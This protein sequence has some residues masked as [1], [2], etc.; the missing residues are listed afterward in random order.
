[1][2]GIIAVCGALL[3]PGCG[4]IGHTGSGWD[5]A[6]APPPAETCGSVRLTSYTASSG[7]WC[8]YDRT[9]A[10]L[11]ASVRAGLTTAI[12]EPWNGG[13]Y[14]GVPGEACGE[15]WEVS[16]I[17]DTRIVMVHDL[18]PIEGN[19]LCAGAHFHFDLAGEAGQ[20]LRGGGL[21]EASTRRVPCPVAGNIHAQ[22]KDRNQWGYL[23]LQLINHRI[24]VRTIDYRAAG[25]ATWRPVQR[26]GG[27]WHVVD[28]PDG[29]FASGSP[30]GV[31]RITSAQGETVE[32]TN[33]LTY[34]IASGS[35]FDLGVQ[36]TDQA[37]ATGAAC[38]FTPPAVVWDDAF[39]G[40]D[41]VRWQVN[42]W[43]ASARVVS[44]GCWG[45]G[46]SCLRI[47]D[48]GPWGGFH[49]YYRQAF[50]VT[51]FATASLQLRAASGGGEV[52]V[53]PSADGVR[54]TETT[55]TL[56]ADWSPVTI[57][58]AATCAGTTSINGITVAN[59]GGTMVMLVDEVRFAK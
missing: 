36:L 2:R 38:V 3:V 57:D 26:S 7:G 58:L 13:S 12:A 25:G 45:G 9:A 30:G 42:P 43:D 49:L 16:T 34:D 53:A 33:V 11:P 22:I 32:A 52:V 47:A 56:G 5:G 15:C 29:V 37:P 28:D 46:G 24:P 41:E 48:L 35:V 40:I 55:V 6:I 39:G 14:G 54:C 21:D 31:L 8:E 23:R 4:K 44:N 50:P 27:A 51:T 10:V 18:C 20:A 17:S 1:M 59:G 19:P